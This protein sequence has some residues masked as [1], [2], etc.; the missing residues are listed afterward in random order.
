MLIATRELKFQ[1][2]TGDDGFR[3]GLPLFTRAKRQ[4][5]G[6]PVFDRMAEWDGNGNTSMAIDSLQALILRYPDASAVASIC[7]DF[8]KTGR[9]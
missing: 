8:H 3:S 1:T 2:E 4:G 9:L 7:S 6:L 5:L